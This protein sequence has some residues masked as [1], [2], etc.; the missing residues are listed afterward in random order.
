LILDLLI[1]WIWFLETSDTSGEGF[2]VAGA[3]ESSPGRS[4]ENKG[5]VRIDWKREGTSNW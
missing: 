1:E 5:A 3:I 2:R 4:K